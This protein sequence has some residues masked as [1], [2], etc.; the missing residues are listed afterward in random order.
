MGNFCCSPIDPMVTS[1]LRCRT[2]F[3]WH[4]TIQRSGGAHKQQ[5]HES[6][7]ANNSNNIHNQNHHDNII[8][9][10]NNNNK[11][12]SLSIFELKTLCPVFM[13]FMGWSPGNGMASRSATSG[14]ARGGALTVFCSA[15][16]D[17]FQ[18]PQNGNGEKPSKSWCFLEL[19][20]FIVYSFREVDCFLTGRS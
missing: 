13:V 16:H 9:N 19:S 20:E 6:A 1:R 8:I 15:A 5:R 12:K 4:P 3:S 10:I 7:Q 14:E 2:E 11:K 18:Y 17:W